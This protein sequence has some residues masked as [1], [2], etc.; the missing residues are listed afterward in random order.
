MHDLRQQIKDFNQAVIEL[1]FRCSCEA[2]PR[3]KKK[4]PI[5]AR[6]DVSP[7]QFR[8]REGDLIYILDSWRVR[9]RC[10]DCRSV[11]T[12]YPP[13]ALPYKRF[14]K[15]VL[16]EHA[17]SYL[18]QDQ[19]YRQTVR[20]THTPVGYDGPK[21]QQQGQQLSRSTV[22]KWLAWLGRLKET[23]QRATSLVLERDPQAN[24]A[25]DVPPISAK[26]FCLSARH[27]VLHFAARLLGAAETAA[28]L[29]GAPFKFTR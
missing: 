8:L 4:A 9:F 10:Q 11:F 2:C 5:F 14:A 3:C 29:I 1:S 18:E 27:D 26:K 17:K 25:R 19:S 12:E 20:G 28:Q 21:G 7:R 6:H 16:V 15:P 24:P 23:L 13:F 22:W